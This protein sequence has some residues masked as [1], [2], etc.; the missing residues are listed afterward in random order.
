MSDP[1]LRGKP[2]EP[3]PLSVMDRLGV[4]KRRV[5]R[6]RRVAEIQAV[7]TAVGEA[8]GGLLAAGLAFNALFA[9]IPALLFMIGLLGFLMGDPAR[10]QEI[11]ESLVDRV[12]A[13]ADFA[14]AILDQ[15][16][17][18]RGAFSVVGIIGVAWGASG[19]Y[20]SLDEAMRRLFPGG[21]PRSIVEQRIRGV[22]AVFGLVGA[23]LAAV[24]ATSVVSLLDAV[25]VLPEGIESVRLISTLLM[26]G[27]FI[28]VVLFTYLVVPTSGPPFRSA[29]LPALLAGTGIGLT[30][31][32]FSVLAP[33]LVGRLSGLGLLATVF[34]ALVWLRL[35][36][37][38]LIYGAGWARIRRDRARRKVTMPTLDPD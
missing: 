26:I 31:A 33:F 37:Q 22:V 34:G 14:D 19:F 36:F 2:A 32:L 1:S 8:S 12:P 6:D 7:M 21:A 30:T 15:L 38:M 3:P 13:V 16:V 28:L 20:G 24:T 35:V 4:V 11:V 9:I 29:L 25:L 27:V 18:G 5:L 10:A 17:A 23:A